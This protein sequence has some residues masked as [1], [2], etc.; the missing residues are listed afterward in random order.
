MTSIIFG[1][2]SAFFTPPL[3][4]LLACLIDALVGDPPA[5]YRQVSH[6]VVLIGS[7]ISLLEKYLNPLK[8][9][10][11][12][13]FIGGALTT[14]IVIL[15]AVFAGVLIALLCDALPLGIVL[16]AILASSLIAGRSL[17]DHVEGVAVGLEQGLDT[18]RRAIAHIVGRDPESLDEAAVSRAAI[19][20]LAENFSDGVVAPVFWFVLLGLPGLLG[21]KAINTLDS[22]IGHHSERYEYFGKAAARLDDLVNYIPARLTGALIVAAAYW[23]TGADGRWAWAAVRHDAARHRSPN[24]GWPE[25]AMAGALGIAL[26]GPRTYAGKEVRDHWMNAPGRRSVGPADIRAALK[27]YGLAC[28]LLAILLVVLAAVFAVAN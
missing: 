18:G 27:V 1:P 10:T 2:G 20:S 26:A 9:S 12:R 22:M 28:G 11:L 8:G 4:V 7:M 14:A 5:L 17:F 13:R 16:L 23:Q 3:I 19:E 25:A 21:Y 15:L 24:A 6:P